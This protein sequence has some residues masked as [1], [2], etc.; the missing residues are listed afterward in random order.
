GHKG[1]TSSRYGLETSKLARLNILI[2][3]RELKMTDNVIN[4]FVEMKDDL[5]S[6]I[7][8]TKGVPLKE[9][10]QEI[11]CVITALD[12]TYP[13]WKDSGYGYKAKELILCSLSQA[14]RVINALESEKSN[15]KCWVKK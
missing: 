3:L 15:A 2:R 14:N 9:W 8:N 1:Y 7:N 13:I 6:S 10:I 12:T 4:M 11:T 5:L